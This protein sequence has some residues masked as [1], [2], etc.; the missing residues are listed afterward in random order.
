MLF[1]LWKALYAPAD[2]GFHN[3]KVGGSIPPPATNVFN[4]LRIVSLEDLGVLTPRSFPKYFIDSD[5]V[6]FGITATLQQLVLST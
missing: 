5:L 1:I 3:P 6:E 2:S 4:D